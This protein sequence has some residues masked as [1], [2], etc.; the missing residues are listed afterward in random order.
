VSRRYR[1]LTWHVHGNYLYYLAHAPHDFHVLSKP[2]RGPGYGGRTGTL[3]WGDNLID[4]PVASLPGREFD[5]VLYQSREHYLNDRETVL[6]VTQRRLPAIYLE[7]DPPLAHPTNTKHP[8]ADP[9]VLVVHVTHYNALMWDNAGP[10]RVVE[11]GVKVPE[12]LGYDGHL[13]RGA[14]VINHLQRRGRR[15]GADVFARMRE[16]VPLDLYGMAAEESGGVG[17]LQ[18]AALMPTLA[19]YRFYAHPV[20]YTSLALALCEAMALGLPVV[21]LATTELPRIVRDGDAGFVDS[22]VDRLIDAANWLI[23]HPAEARRMGER[24]QAVARE[25]FGIDRF[26][27]DWDRVFRDFLK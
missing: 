1:I 26:A 22:D 6:S 21:G 25:R 15:L 20:R 18:Y 27:A 8:V 2:E 14:V 24:A 9:N 7:H 23:A 11:H 5:C 19:S 10:V 17:E 3:P 13:P 4:C 12:G 16:R